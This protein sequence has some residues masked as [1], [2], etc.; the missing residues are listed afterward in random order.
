MP[1]LQDYMVQYDHEHLNPWNKALHSVGIPIIFAGIIFL[2]LT[3]WKLGLA[4]FVGGW[5]L[6][7]LGHRI[8]GNKPAF[9]QGPVYFLVGPLWVAKE[10]RDAVLGKRE[11]APAAR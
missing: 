3:R 5:V 7:F 1:S 2:I 11:R 10:I 9:F 4:L 6:L 8:E